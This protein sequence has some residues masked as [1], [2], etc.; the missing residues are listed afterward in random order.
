MR[1]RICKLGSIF[2][3]AAAIFRKS[4][5]YKNF[6]NIYAEIRMVYYKIRPFHW[7]PRFL[8]EN[9]YSDE[10]IAEFA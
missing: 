2:D 4:T 6:F 3:L 9:K 1:R 5:H 7:L 10:I 8:R